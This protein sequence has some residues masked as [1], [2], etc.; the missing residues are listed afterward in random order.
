MI[1]SFRKFFEFAGRQS[2]NWYLGLFYEIIRCVL[3]AL[4]FAALLVVLDGL[5]HESITAQTALTAFG[6]MLTSVVGT[7]IFWYLAHGKEGEGSY[8]MCEDKRIQIGNRM[9]YMPM[10][11][12]NSHSLGNLTSVST[13]TMSDLESMSFAVIVRTLVGVIHASIFSAAM[14]YFSWKISL[15]F[16]LGVILFMIINTMLLRCSRRLSPKRLEAQTEFMDA[17]LE[18]IQGMGVVRAFHMADQSNTAMEKT[19][20][21]TQRKNML[22]ERRRIPYIAAE[23]AILRI[24]S[25]AAAF[26][27]IALFINGTLE[28]TY[29]LMI[30]VSAFM[31]YSQLESAGEMFF[32]LSM[33]DASID[34]V[35]EIN[36]SPQIDIDGKE[37]NPGRL[38]IEMQDVSFSYGD[39]KV[40]DHVSLSIP[41]GT[42]TAIV[43]PSGSGKTTLVNLIARF[44]MLAAAASVSAVL[45]SGNI[46]W[47]A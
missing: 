37:Q 42:T 10:G 22:L 12:F 13:A 38:D 40:I 44:G 16:L 43:G 6:I 30:L 33:I 2:R 7:I 21:E 46:N 9:K 28:L 31:V 5:V 26:C 25:A 3:E 35:E 47:T 23:Q 27:S 18:Y 17:V 4:Q 34:R 32:M 39:K 20:E 15:V 11:Y 41:Q 36:Q 45:T 8:R 14:C 19:I 1:R 29:C 24:A